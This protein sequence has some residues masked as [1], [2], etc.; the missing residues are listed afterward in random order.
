[1][2]PNV[3]ATRPSASP[4]RRSQ[5]IS[6]LGGAAL[7]IAF[8]LPAVHTCGHDE[9]PVHYAGAALSDG[10]GHWAGGWLL[11]VLP[12]L[13]GALFGLAALF[14]L[15]TGVAPRMASFAVTAAA[16]ACAVP[17]VGLLMTRRDDAV[18]LLLPAGCLVAT[19]ILVR[20]RRLGPHAALRGGLFA[21]VV[22]TGWFLVIG[23][24]PDARYGAWVSLAA[25]VALLVAHG[26][27]GYRILGRRLLWSPRAQAPDGS[28]GVGP[29]R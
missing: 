10:A 1:M 27:E 2:L 7:V 4:I 6:A 28:A 3:S 11:G 15:R 25:Y 14:R 21:G 18:E 19:L 23:V 22:G 17:V 13:V 5:S 16:I 24:A 29:Y 20:A 9:T 26:H 12:Y 8:F